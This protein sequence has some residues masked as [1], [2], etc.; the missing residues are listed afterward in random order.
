VSGSIAGDLENIAA[1][2]VFAATAPT[3]GTD[4]SGGVLA[5]NGGPTET[6]ALLDA[7][8]NPALARG[9]PNDLDTDQRGEPRPPSGGSPDIGAFELEQSHATVAG[10]VAGERLWGSRDDEALIGR[11]GND[12]L[13]GR[14]GDDLLDGGAGCDRLHA[15]QGS[16]VL[17]GGADADRFI[18]GA[19]SHSKPSAPDTILDFSPGEGDRID[20]RPLDADPCRPGDQKLEFIDGE[21]FTAAGQVRQASVDGHTVVE[22]NLD[23]DAHA[24]LTVALND[25]INLHQGDFLL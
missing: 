23:Q 7:V 25:A 22:V 9:E 4:A 1:Q 6:V 19:A 18:F 2:S 5:D 12:R 14:A 15:G 17:I 8:A 11:S 16:D 3:A 21:T 24:E 13:H 20:L 10:T